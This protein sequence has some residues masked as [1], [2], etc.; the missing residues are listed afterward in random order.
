M[1]SRPQGNQRDLL[2]PQVWAPRGHGTLSGP[3]LS[4]GH[5]DGSLPACRWGCARPVPAL[6]PH[7]ALGVFHGKLGPEPSGALGSDTAWFKTAAF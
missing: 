2:R 6:G 7:V 1:S 5:E 3:V 4:S